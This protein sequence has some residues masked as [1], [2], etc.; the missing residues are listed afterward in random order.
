MPVENQTLAPPAHNFPEFPGGIREFGPNVSRWC[1]FTLLLLNIYRPMHS[2]RREVF[3]SHY[4]SSA[5][6]LSFSDF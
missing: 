4:P 1:G 3:F 5:F 6:C 2:G